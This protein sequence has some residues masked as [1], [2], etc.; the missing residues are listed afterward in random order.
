MS[1]RSLLV[2]LVTAVL[3]TVVSGCGDS[4]PGQ[5]STF[6]AVDASG[7]DYDSVITIDVDSVAGIRQQTGTLVMDLRHAEDYRYR[8]LWLELSYRPTDSVVVRD[9]FNIIMCDIHGNWLGSGSGPSISITDTLSRSYT[10]PRPAVLTLRHIMRPDTVEHI[11]RIGITF[12]PE[13]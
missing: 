4:V 1:L 13:Q 8:N 5:F 9:T 12:I 10:L 11:E 6:R 3:A 7:W 2:F